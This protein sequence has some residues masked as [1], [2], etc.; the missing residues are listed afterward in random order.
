MHGDLI[1]DTATQATGHS[2]C[3]AAYD[4]C[5]DDAGTDPIDNIMGYSHACR[6]TFSPGQIRRM[7]FLWRT[8]RGGKSDDVP[9]E[10]MEAEATGCAATHGG[11][12]GIVLLVLALMTTTRRGSATRATRHRR[13]RRA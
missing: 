9:V 5:P 11:S 4:S 2:S 13:G 6:G 7:K 12:L 10:D 1:R 3:D 8:V